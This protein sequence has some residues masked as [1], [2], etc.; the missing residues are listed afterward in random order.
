L[1]GLNFTFNGLGEYTLLKVRTENI[2]FDLQARTERA[3]KQDGSLSE[4]T[5]FSAFAAKD[6][7]GA[8]FHVEM[9]K[10]KNGNI[11]CTCA[12]KFIK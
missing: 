5:V 7:S 3:R 12:P 9:N 4:A 2:S 1:D 11:L 8:T 6:S 10:A